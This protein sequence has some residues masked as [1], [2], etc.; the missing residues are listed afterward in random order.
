MAFARSPVPRIPGTD[1]PLLR[2]DPVLPSDMATVHGWICDEKARVWLDLGGGRQT[3]SAREFFLLL[4]APRNHAR[5]FR[6]PQGGEPL[7]LSCLNDVTNLM[8]S[9]EIWGMRG[10]YARGP[11]HMAAAAMLLMLADGFVDHGRAVIGSWIVD[12]NVLSIGMHARLGMRQAGRQR[13][14]HRIGDTYYDRLLFDM[15][16]AEFA[17]LYPDVAASSGAT[18]RSLAGAPAGVCVR[19]TEDA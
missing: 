1:L 10:L 11:R 7:G 5:L 19:E 17:A 4:T 8:G 9:A 18:M 16:R 6:A 15:T 2:M 13:A 14:R 12:G 3:L